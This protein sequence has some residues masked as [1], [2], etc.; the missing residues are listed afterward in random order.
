MLKHI[1]KILVPELF[2][3]MMEMGHG[4]EILLC[5]GNYPARTTGDGEVIYLPN[6]TV[7]ELLEAVLYYLPLDQSVEEAA[8]VMESCKTTSRF[9]E[10][11]KL[12][13]KSESEVK[14]V[15][16]FD[17][18]DLAAKAVVKAVTT[19]TAKG[20]NILLKKGVVS[21]MDTAQ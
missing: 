19:D 6:C 10:Y 13:R 21:D 2:K 7:T 3:V 4:E 9:E 11:Q 5:D 14:T 17:F 12:V 15:P 1:P 8:I 20:G 18:Y 16:R